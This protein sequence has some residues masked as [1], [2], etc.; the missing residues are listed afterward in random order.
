MNN[1]Q[2]L[3]ARTLRSQG[4]SYKMIADS[5]GVTISAVRWLLNRGEPRELLGCGT[6]AGY[7]MH[8]RNGEEKCEPCKAAHAEYQRKYTRKRAEQKWGTYR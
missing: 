5:I 6:N 8:S 1:Q 7:Q 3:K 2:A 4:W